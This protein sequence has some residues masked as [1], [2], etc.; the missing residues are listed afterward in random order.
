MR[1]NKTLNIDRFAALQH[2]IYHFLCQNVCGRP[3]ER[4]GQ[5]RQNCERIAK[6]DREMGIITTDLKN[7][8]I[9]EVAVLTN[10]FHEDN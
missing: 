10:G 3:Y 4:C 5:D 9:K 1:I 6:V 2:V 8:M 7:P